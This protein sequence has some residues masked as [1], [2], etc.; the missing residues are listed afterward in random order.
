MIIILFATFI[1]CNF[2]QL[3][4]VHSLHVLERKSVKWTHFTVISGCV[5]ARSLLCNQERFEATL[6]W[7][8]MNE[9]QFIQ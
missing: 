5:F 4:R 8:F 1:V 9:I 3:L 6:F 7:H 2:L